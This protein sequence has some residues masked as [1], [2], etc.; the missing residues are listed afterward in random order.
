MSVIVTRDPAKPGWR[1]PEAAAPLR[2]PD[3]ADLPGL[4][5]RHRNGCR[6]L[7][8]FVVANRA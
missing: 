8:R 3:H 5:E 7:D 1:E 6:I 4:P 2:L